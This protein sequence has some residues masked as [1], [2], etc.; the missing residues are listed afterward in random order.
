MF[1]TNNLI[2]P[3]DYII[4]YNLYQAAIEKK[5]E[6]DVINILLEMSMT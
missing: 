1:Y 3:D 5:K 2:T 6:D 4:I